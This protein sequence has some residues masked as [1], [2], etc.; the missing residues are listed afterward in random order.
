MGVMDVG[1]KGSWVSSGVVSRCRLGM[2]EASIKT[3]AQAIKRSD[4][5][6]YEQ[7][8]DRKQVTD[9]FDRFLL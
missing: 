5:V 2:N 3:Q 7:Q 9:T 4:C 6:K 8:T 1:L